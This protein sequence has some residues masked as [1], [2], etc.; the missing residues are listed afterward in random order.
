MCIEFFEEFL[1]FLILIFWIFE[2]I[3]LHLK[4]LRIFIEFLTEFLTNSK[5]NLKNIR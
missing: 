4:T 3:L 2:E 5:T 1:W